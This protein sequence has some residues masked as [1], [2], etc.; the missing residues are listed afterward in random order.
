MVRR[1]SWLI[2][3]IGCFVLA[4]GPFIDIGSTRIPLPYAIVHWLLGNQYRTPM[5][6]ATPGV[7]ALAMFVAS[8]LDRF[9]TQLN[10]D[11]VRRW[12]PSPA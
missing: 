3:A 11:R 6:F 8:S 1:W 5:R 7:F 12:S 2:V 9:L 10:L 4:L